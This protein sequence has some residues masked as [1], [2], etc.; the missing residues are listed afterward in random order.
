[1]TYLKI[2]CD[3]NAAIPAQNVTLDRSG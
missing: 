1:M 3:R 2:R